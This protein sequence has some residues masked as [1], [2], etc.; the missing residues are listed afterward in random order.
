MSIFFGDTVLCPLSD[1]HAF[2]W[3]WTDS[4]V[5]L[6]FVSPPQADPSNEKLI[7]PRGKLWGQSCC[8]PQV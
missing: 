7:I 4:F 5:V 8:S 2:L 6:A 1:T 3:V